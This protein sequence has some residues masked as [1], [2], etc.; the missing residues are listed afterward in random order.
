MR[1]YIDELSKDV[2]KE[3]IGEPV[4]K[5][6]KQGGKY[7][8][9]EYMCAP[10]GFD[11]EN[12]KQYMYIWT[13]SINDL[14]VI[15]YTWNEFSKLLSMIKSI[16]ALCKKEKKALR[17][18]PIFVHN[19]AHEYNFFKYELNISDA[20]FIDENNP[21]YVVVD[22][23][24]VFI[25]SYKISGKNLETT[26]EM[27]GCKHRKTHDLDYSIPRNT[28]D[29]KNLSEAEL[30]YCCNDTQILVEVADYIFKNYFFKYN[31]L[32]FTMNKLVTSIVKSYYLLDKEKYDKQLTRLH[33][34]KDDYQQLRINAF[35]GGFSGV[36]Y[37]G[38]EVEKDIMY[39]D[40]DAAYC[41]AIC[42]GYYP[43]TKFLKR[44]PKKE[45]FLELVNTHCVIATVKFTNFIAKGD[46]CCEA[47]S[48]VFGVKNAEWKV[49]GK[50]ESC[51]EFTTTLCELDWLNF[52]DCYDWTDFEVLEM[53]SAERGS[54]FE[55]VIQA[56]IQLYGDKARLKKAGKKKSPEYLNAKTLVS[57]IFGA[58]V[59]K[60]DM[61]KSDVSFEMDAKK[62]FLLPQWGVYVTAHVRRVVVHMASLMDSYWLYSNTD[63]LIAIRNNYTTSMI[64]NFN[65]SVKLLNK[66]LCD[67]YNLDFNIYDNL[68]C[69]DTSASIK[70]FKANTV[71]QYM[72]E[73]ENGHIECVYGGVAK[74]HEYNGEKI[75]D[76]LYYY[77]NGQYEIKG[78]KVDIKDYYTPFEFLSPSV[79]IP[80]YRTK[81][82]VINTPSSEYINGKIM[83]SKSGV[84]I[85][86]NE[87]MCCQAAAGLILAL[88]QMKKKENDSRSHYD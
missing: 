32:P 17:A 75:S 77:Y 47:R 22:E 71:N 36:A 61:K 87:E 80:I 57:N 41:Y 43:V 44:A 55:Y 21:M 24:F 40:L 4:W 64:E 13:F 1:V 85:T 18:L 83:T 19:L 16:Y 65:A 86:S 34:D 51:D 27:F 25:D 68:G 88:T 72:Y 6:N 53:H 29:A 54:I 52:K 63:S 39:V 50:L 46:V 60:D 84:I 28:D 3:H 62:K 79:K 7:T 23:A 56:A 69:F 12:Y 58:M 31:K 73:E 11:I 81:A 78:E 76:L 82:E 49:G 38:M 45:L 15:G 33:L 48:H 66:E 35:R 20:F 42:H 26:A 67:K 70:K 10:C 59:K 5:F 9:V 30:D 37:P 2:L 8:V 14:T 74:R